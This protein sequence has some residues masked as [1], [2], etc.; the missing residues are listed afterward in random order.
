MRK[1]EWIAGLVYLAVLAV[2]PVAGHWARQGA[3]PACAHDGGTIEPR[4][5]VR[6]VDDRGRDFEFCCIH[7]AEAWLRGEKARPRA[8]FVTDETSGEEIEA[9]TA[10]FVR[11]LL[12]TNP[13]TNNRVHAF[14][15]ETDAE[16]HARASHGRL[17]DGS[18]RPF[19]ESAGSTCPNCD[20]RE[21]EKE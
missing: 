17:L 16:T 15:N 5:R 4:Y 8:V 1:P 12:V 19:L 9:R 13:T 20:Q 6:I 7:C 11:S 21:A 18:E 14:R 2:L 3:E 10:H